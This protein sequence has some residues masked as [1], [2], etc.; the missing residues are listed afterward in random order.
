MRTNKV[1]ELSRY[2]YLDTFRYLDDYGFMNFEDDNSILIFDQTDGE[3]TDV[4]NNCICGQCE[5]SFNDDDD[6][7]QYSELEQDYVCNDCSA[8]IDERDDV[9][10]EANATYNNYSGYYHYS[11]DLS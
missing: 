8:Y 5:T 9:C 1:K 10:F 3:V 11:E 7:I 4:D 6:E 2:P